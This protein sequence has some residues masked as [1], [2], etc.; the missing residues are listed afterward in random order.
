MESDEDVF[1]RSPSGMAESYASSPSADPDHIRPRNPEQASYMDL[2]MR[3]DRP[4]IVIATGA[5][6]SGKTWMA[7]SVAM[8]RLLSGDIAK[9]VITRPIVSVD[10]EELGFLPGDLTMKMQPWLRP[11]TDVFFKF[12]TPQKFESLLVRQI[13][14]ICPLAMMRGRSFEDAYII[15]DEAQNT[16]PAQMLMLLTRIGSGSKI[17]VT[18]DPMQHDRGYDT[19]GLSDLIARLPP[20]GNDNIAIVRFTDEHIQRHPIV[21]TVLHLYGV[22]YLPNA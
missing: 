12:I 21:R 15:I 3:R 2:L 7:C 5:A 13:I 9:I 16:S 8:K 10:S 6:G 20:T 1:G 19:N 18:G 11:I 14:E 22:H 17:I 4:A